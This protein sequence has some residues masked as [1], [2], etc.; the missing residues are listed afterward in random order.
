MTLKDLHIIYFLGIGGIGMS[1]LARYF[2]AQGVK[3]SGYDKTRTPLTDLLESEGIAVHFDEDIQAIPANPDLIVVTPAIPADNT[4]LIFLQK[5]GATL[6]KRAAVLG[7]LSADMQ[8]IAVAGT[9]E[10][11]PPPP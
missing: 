5:S 8:C 7:L 4:E 2:H 10:R 6:M 9:H 11:P 3:V 1:A